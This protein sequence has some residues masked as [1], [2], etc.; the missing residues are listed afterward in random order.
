M[1]S[2]RDAYAYVYPGKRQDIGNPDGYYSALTDFW[3]F[4]GS[5]IV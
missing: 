3:A 5:L 2:E 1:L 4:G